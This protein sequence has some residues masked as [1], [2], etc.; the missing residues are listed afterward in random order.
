MLEPFRG[1]VDSKVRDIY[2][3]EGRVDE[4]EQRIKAQLLEVLYEPVIIGGFKG[5]LMV[6]LHRTTASLQRCFGGEQKK[7]DLPEL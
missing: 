4:L 2:E 3:Q 1:F 7:L 6:G 5:P